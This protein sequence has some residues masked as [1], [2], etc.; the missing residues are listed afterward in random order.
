[1]SVWV[2]PEIEVDLEYRGIT[3]DGRLRHATFKR[4]REDLMRPR[5]RGGKSNAVKRLKYNVQR[6]LPDAVVPGK[7]ELREYWRK[8]GKAALQYIGGRP[9]TL[10]RHVDGITFFHTRKL[11]QMPWPVHAMHF[12]KQEGGEGVRAYV[13]SVQG[14]LGLVDMDVIEVHP[15]NATVDDI[16]HPDQMIFD[17]DPHESVPWEFV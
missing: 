7:D 11:P 6:L 4:V 17:L 13:D 16:E 5:M 9:L 8:A 15:W 2:E 12:E 14:L 1:K 10:V 3:G